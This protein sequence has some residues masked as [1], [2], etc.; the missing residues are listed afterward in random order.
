MASND[1]GDIILEVRDLSVSFDVYGRISHVLDGITFKVK[2]GERVGL[3]GESGCGKTTTL[4]A[5]LNVLPKNAIVKSGDI[6]FEGK[7]VFTMN[8]S[9]LST[10]RRTGAGMVFQDPS[11]ALN[12][13]FNIENQFVTALKFAKPKNTSYK[14]LYRTA[15]EALNNV[16]L[17]DPERIM[18]SFPYQLSG[19]MKQRVCIA[20]TIA[21]GRQLLMAD[22]P[23]TSL[24]VTIQDQIL[25]LI[26]KLVIEEHLS[27]IMVSHSLGVIRESTSY[28]NIMYAGT[29]VE[30]GTSN[31]VFNYPKHPY[32]FALMACVPKLTGEGIAAGIPGRVPDYMMPP[33]GCRFSPRCPKA[34]DIC[35]SEKP[36]H[37]ETSPNHYVSCYFANE[38]I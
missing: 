14:V 8:P 19:G 37:L 34:Q 21:A 30:S 9:R 27:V 3:V 5:I 33:K 29:V 38:V 6:I 31:D 23:G 15:V 25:R 35:R 13:V 10:M 20:M 22:E 11:S 24:D 32:T 17:P 12:P 18:K 16:M 28:V 4:R 2:K 1:S 36:P 26:N 7:N